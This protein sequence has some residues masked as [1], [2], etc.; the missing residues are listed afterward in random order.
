[1]SGMCGGVKGKSK[2]Y[3]VGI[4]ETCHQNDAGKWEDGAWKP[5]VYSVPMDHAF[6]VKL[7]HLVS[8]ENFPDL[9]AQGLKVQKSELPDESEELDFDIFL[10]PESSGSAVLAD[11]EIVQSISGQQR[12]LSAFE[13]ESFALYESAR[14]SPSKPL[15]F[16][17]KA[18]V[19]DGSTSKATLIIALRASY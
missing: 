19:D 16:S 3:D 2:I 5:E 1:M 15:Y 13:M 11:A 12:K 6:A 7:D 4:P 14:L 8:Q 18:V 9:V 10:A 17:A